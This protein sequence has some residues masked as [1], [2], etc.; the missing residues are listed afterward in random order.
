MTDGDESRNQY[1]SEEAYTVAVIT[2]NYY[3]FG[4]TEEE[5]IR[6]CQE[7]G[8]Y[9]NLKTR[10]FAAYWFDRPVRMAVHP[11]YGNLL[12]M[13][14]DGSDAPQPIAEEVHFPDG[15]VIDRVEVRSGSGDS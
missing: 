11:L 1:Y 12:W 6:N 3:G 7:V 9:G 15:A 4:N 10:G 13:T 5:A 8:G 2:S 14:T